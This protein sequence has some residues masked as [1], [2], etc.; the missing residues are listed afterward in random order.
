MYEELNHIKNKAVLNN[1]IFVGADTIIRSRHWR[2]IFKIALHNK[3][4]ETD[5]SI[6]LSSIIFT[7]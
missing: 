3:I 6:L 4:L 5:N 2:I 7:D 1:H